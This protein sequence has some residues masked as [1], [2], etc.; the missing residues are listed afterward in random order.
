MFNRKT[1]APSCINCRRTAVFSVAGRSVQMILVLRTS[2]EHRARSGKNKAES[3]GPPASQ[4][5][6]TET[7]RF[8]RGSDRTLQRLPAMPDATLLSYPA[9]MLQKDRYPFHRAR[10]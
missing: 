7:R 10:L 9:D 2:A 6:L 1:S 4:H 3:V 8:A 5:P